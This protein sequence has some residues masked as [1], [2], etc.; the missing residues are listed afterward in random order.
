MNMNNTRKMLQIGAAAAVAVVVNLAGVQAAIIA[1]WQFSSNATLLDDSSGNNY[2]LA[3][4]GGVT[5]SAA[6]GGSAVFNGS[7]MLNTVATLNLTPYSQI[8]IEWGMRTIQTDPAIVWEQSSNAFTTPNG[9]YSA[10][11]DSP[12]V[13]T[14]DFLANRGSAGGTGDA[15]IGYTTVPSGGGL[16]SYAMM[17]DGP[18]T[19]TGQIQLFK[20]GVDVTGQ[21]Y[22][23]FTQNGWTQT[24][25]NDT[26]FIG[27]RSGVAAGFN[28]S[29]DYL[30]VTGVVPEPS[31]WLLLACGLTFVTVMRRRAT[32]S[33]NL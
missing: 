14:I 11:N 28:G 18:A 24:F 27:A 13:G 19:N 31:T 5:W 30:T 25:L 6:D 20:D 33:K 4:T 15:V 10:I 1:D 12:G 22:G 23:I 16:H 21:Y 7:A 3:N 29:I 32:R 26:L 8:T 17:I 9:L 2:I